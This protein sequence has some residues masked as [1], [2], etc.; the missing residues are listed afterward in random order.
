MGRLAASSTGVLAVAVLDVAVSRSGGW[1]CSGCWGCWTRY[2]RWR[3]LW[4]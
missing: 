2:E 3:P 1:T 4:R